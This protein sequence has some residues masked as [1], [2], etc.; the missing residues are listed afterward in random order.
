MKKVFNF[1][2]PEPVITNEKKVP[3]WEQ[4]W[5]SLSLISIFG[6]V[7][8]PKKKREFIPI[9]V[10]NIAVAILIIIIVYLV[11]CGA[12]MNSKWIIEYTKG[13]SFSLGDRFYYFGIVTILFLIIDCF[14][15]DEKLIDHAHKKKM[16]KNTVNNLSKGVAS[17]PSSKPVTKNKFLL[18]ITSIC[19]FFT[20]LWLIWGIIFYDRILFIGLMGS[21][22]LFAIITGA[23]K[24]VKYTKF[25]FF[26]EIVVNIL[27]ILFILI[28]HFYF[29]IIL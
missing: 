4:I 21:S 3:W 24:N 15:L 12:V 10:R 17:M 26:I 29:K 25:I 23:I 19:T 6:D 13:A 1:S 7:V 22:I 18:I 16:I 20:F 9:A 14:Y 27:C 28:N 11:G 5:A 2:N 8:I